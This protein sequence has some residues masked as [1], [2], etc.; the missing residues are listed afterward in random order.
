MVTLAL[1]GAGYWGKN[2]LRIL[3]EI[4][5]VSLKYC[6][7]ADKERVQELQKKHA[8][9]TFVSETQHIFTDASVDA[10][11]I[12]TPP[13]SH[14][15]LAQEALLAKKDILV[16]KPLA[17]LETETQQLLA[18]AQQ[19]QKILMVGHTYLY[20]EG[21]QKCHQLL[22][23][24]E[25]GSLM[26]ATFW[27]TG[28]SPIRKSVN[29]LWD[30][31]IHDVATAFFLF[32]VPHQV[33]CVGEAHLQEG[34]EDF[35]QATLSYPQGKQVFLFA[36]WFYPEKMRKMIL[37]G[38]EKMLIFDDVE[39]K[40][41]ILPVTL[42]CS[43]EISD[44]HD[45]ALEAQCLDKDKEHFSFAE[46]EPLKSQVLHFLDCMNSR[47]SPLSDGKHAREVMQVM[48]ALEMSLKNKGKITLI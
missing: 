40:L 46:T 15:S 8:K 28:F 27:R 17:L 9:V 48:S 4:P 18:L 11:I 41:E 45:H 26:N 33:S 21:V 20:N 1:I 13:S 35:V 24:G 39:K 31:A 19:Q 30:L 25:L 22:R 5:G 7:D 47:T 43:P 38:K 23:A 34:R 14:F 44:L 2:Y 37:V 6:C 32:G 42:Q 12:A 36:S 16:E 10:V 29:A 3:Q